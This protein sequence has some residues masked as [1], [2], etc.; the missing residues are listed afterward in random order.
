MLNHFRFLR[1]LIPFSQHLHC[2]CWWYSLCSV[3]ISDMNLVVCF[4]LFSWN[5]YIFVKNLFSFSFSFSSLSVKSFLA[6]VPFL[7]LLKTSGFLT[8]SWGTEMEHCLKMGWCYLI[9]YM[10]TDIIFNLWTINKWIIVLMCPTV[11]HVKWYFVIILFSILSW[12]EF[13]LFSLHLSCHFITRVL[14][15]RE[16]N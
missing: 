4:Y 1:M 6:N 16:T 11:V 12:L 15:A 13:E 3:A 14:P 8:F 9:V 10:Y 2:S 5:N 7:Y